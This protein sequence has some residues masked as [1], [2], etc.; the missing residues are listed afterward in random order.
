MNITIDLVAGPYGQDKVTKQQIQKNIDAL[1][2]V[3]EGKPISAADS[4]YLI[5]TLYIIMDIKKQLPK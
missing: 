1:K 2:R 5:D 4:T 3:I